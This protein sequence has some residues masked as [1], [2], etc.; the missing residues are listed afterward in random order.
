MT[1]QYCFDGSIKKV[2]NLSVSSPRTWG[3]FLKAIRLVVNDVVFPTHVGVFLYYEPDHYHHRRLPHARGGVSFVVRRAIE[4]GKS[5]P[6]TW[7]CFPT[8]PN[9]E[10][11]HDVFPTHV[12]VFLSLRFSTCLQGC[13][14]HARGGVSAVLTQQLETALSSP[15]TWGCFFSSYHFL[16]FRR[17]FPTHVG[18]FLPRPYADPAP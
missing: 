7:G 3:C 9:G 12:G 16:R 18:V 11:D 15:R 13:L 5:S 14:P 6:R 4:A 2:N 1:F 17:V 10:Y 8:T